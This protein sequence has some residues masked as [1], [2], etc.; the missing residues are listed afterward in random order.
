MD[1]T[2]VD[3]VCVVIA[4]PAE[5]GGLGRKIAAIKLCR[6]RTGWGLKE[7]KDHVEALL[8]EGIEQVFAQ[9]LIDN[10]YQPAIQAVGTAL[11]IATLDQPALH[12]AEYE[13]SQLRSRVEEYSRS[14]REVREDAMRQT[15]EAN[16]LRRE[17]HHAKQRSNAL[18]QAL[19]D[20]AGAL[21]EDVGYE[22]SDN[23]EDRGH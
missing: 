5:A 19:R 13:V 20:V 16:R 11:H 4:G 7:A 15:S 12:N 9:T 14:L 10:N 23:W 2:S 18:A 22:D 21:S 1:T 3:L 8:D 17:L 6:E